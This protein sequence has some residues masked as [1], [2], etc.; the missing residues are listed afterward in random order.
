[1]VS[2][3]SSCQEHEP[4]N[5]EMNHLKPETVSQNP[6]FLLKVVHVRV[7]VTVMKRLTNT[8]Y[9]EFFKC[10]GLITILA[11]ILI[12]IELY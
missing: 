6:P 11:Y 3:R 2:S 5:H 1:M 8:I 9:K 7:S 10:E 4:S 12:L